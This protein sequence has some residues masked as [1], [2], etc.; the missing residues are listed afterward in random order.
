VRARIARPLADLLLFGALLTA[1]CAMTIAALGPAQVWDNLGAY[2]AGAGHQF[3]AD[4]SANLRLTVNV[5]RQEPP[6]LYVL[7]GAGLLIG[8][9]RRRTLTIALVAWALAILALFSVYGDLADKHIVYLVPPVALLGALGV[10]LLAEAVATLLAGSRLGRRAV[11]RRS[12][13]LVV[14]AIGV[15]GVAGYLWFLPA[16][17]RADVFLI[18]EA[19]KLAAERRGKAVDLEIAE[20]IRA[21]TPPDG[22]VLSDNP[23][24][25]FEA[26]RLV[27]PYLVD[28]SGTRVDAGSLTSEVAIHEAERFR[29]LV[30]VTTRR[31]LGKL[32]GFNRW[33]ASDFRLVRTYAATDP[34]FLLYVRA[35]LEPQ[36]RA[37]LEGQHR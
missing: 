25:A 9:W 6:G 30:I 22:W 20:I 23:G 31:R 8:L 4:R 35:D 5:M 2:R 37:F 18:R 12:R 13:T 14:L 32:E 7:A 24:A 27:I 21:R 10:G 29:P 36:A 28:T 15:A 19:P 3:G 34:P 11:M 16:L 17:Y 26:R 1:I 33:L